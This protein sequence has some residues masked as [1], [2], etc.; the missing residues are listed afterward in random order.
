M[1][2]AAL[3]H[4]RGLEL[5][6]GLEIRRNATLP[7]L[8]SFSRT[9]GDSSG[10]LCELFGTCVDM[11]PQLLHQHDWRHTIGSCYFPTGERPGLQR[12]RRLC[13]RRPAPGLQVTQRPNI[14]AATPNA[15]HPWMTA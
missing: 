12:R 11:G 15:P 1:E 8:S 6:H 3:L 7:P 2:A 9:L 4:S 5:V 10:L 14:A 13:A